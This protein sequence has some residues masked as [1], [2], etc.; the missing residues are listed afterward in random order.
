MGKYASG[1]FAK[2]ISD[3]SGMAFPYNEMVKEWNGSTVHI[4]EFEAKHPQLEPLPIVT[5][6]QSL[7][8]ARG[9]I[10]VSRVF[11]GGATGPINAGTTV[12]KPDGS[13]AAYSG[14]GFG[15]NVNSF[16]TADQVVTHTRDDGSTFTITTKSM[17]P[18]ELQA[19]KKPTRLLSAV[20]NVTVSTS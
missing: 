5:D 18:L 9:Q 16:E 17:M 3:R 6:P 2:R 13:D 10:A 8:N 1:K 7:E 20:G 12:V 11:V 15:L 4:S 14:P 19:P